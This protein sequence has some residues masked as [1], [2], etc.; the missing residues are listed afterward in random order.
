MGHEDGAQSIAFS[1]DGTPVLTALHDIAKTRSTQS[2]ACIQTF[3]GHEEYAQS[4]AF[5]G[6]GT[7]VLAAPHDITM[8]AMCFQEHEKCVDSGVIMHKYFNETGRRELAWQ[9]ALQQIFACE[10]YRNT[11]LATCKLKLCKPRFVIQCMHIFY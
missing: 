4:I 9:L 2:G 5:S 1:G 8:K 6:D 3:T 11:K 10:L 7:P